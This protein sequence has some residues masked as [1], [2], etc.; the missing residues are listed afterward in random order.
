MR[1]K[2]ICHMWSS[3]DGRLYLQRFTPPFDGKRH[4]EDV[5]V[6]YTAVSNG[7]KAQALLVGRKTMQDHGM[8][9]SFEGKDSSPTRHP[10]TYQGKRSSERAVVIIDPKG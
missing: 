10:A 8:G 5:A 1:P 4:L 7:F 9:K 3:V 2:V 6:Q